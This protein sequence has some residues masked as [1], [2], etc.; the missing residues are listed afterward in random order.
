MAGNLAAAAP[1]V[2]DNVDTDEALREYYDRLGVPG[3]ILR[4]QDAVD[5]IRAD[6]AQQEQQ[7]QM[8]AMMPAVKDGADAAKLLSET[9]L[10]GGAGIPALAGA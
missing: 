7:Q 4:D 6:R 8:A 2:M 9:G 10:L 5:K 3:R 1:Q